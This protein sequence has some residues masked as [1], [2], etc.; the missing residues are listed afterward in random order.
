MTD[1]KYEAFLARSLPDLFWGCA[2]LAYTDYPV[3]G[4]AG[5]QRD[6]SRLARR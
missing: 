3:A 4:S 6:L 5:N 2:T 1:D